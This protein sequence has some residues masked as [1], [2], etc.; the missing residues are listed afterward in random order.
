MG[1]VLGTIFMTLVMLAWN[2]VLT[3][4]Y[5]GTPRAAVAT[6]L[7]PVFLPFNLLK[8]SLNAAITLLLYRPLVR[9]LRS[10]G[11]FPRSAANVLPQKRSKILLWIGA[12][13]V[14]VCCVLAILHYNGII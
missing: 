2:Y 9:G 14:I 3:P 6:M 10:A 13:A 5:M 8:G 1:L 11:L 12:G 4:I 7:I